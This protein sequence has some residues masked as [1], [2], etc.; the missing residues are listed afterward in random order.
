MMWDEW[1]EA[2][3]L[4]RWMKANKVTQTQVAVQ[5]DRSPYAVYMWLHG[6]IPDTMNAEWF[7]DGMR[8]M[9]GIADFEEQW[10][11]WEQTRPEL[12]GKAV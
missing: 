12:E 9:T 4:K 3:P 6:I 11:K 5:F 2:N 1:R 8:S 7:W 10:R